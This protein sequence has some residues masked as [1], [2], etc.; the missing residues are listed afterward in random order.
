MLTARDY[1]IV[2]WVGRVGGATAGH[3]MLRFGMGRTA[4]YRRLAHAT[5]DGL[6]DSAQLLYGE[7]TVYV[8]TRRGLRWTGLGH[9]PTGGISPATVAHTM[10]CT[11]V[12]LE[13]EA[14]GAAVVGEREFRAADAASDRPFASVDLPPSHG[15]RAPRHRPDLVVYPGGT[16]LPVAI[17]VELSVKS[18]RRLDLI[19]R[20]WGRARHIA[21]VRYYATP[22][23]ARAVAQA[24]TRTGTE[25][26]VDIRPLPPT[27]LDRPEG[28]SSCR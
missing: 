28:I 11:R 14:E 21:G 8:P 5:H 24:I 27:H 23:V 2:Q 9:L 1:E 6:L 19:C 15:A 17:E 7:P 20:A 18:A 25:G 16:E 4:V 12:W 13:L 22:A 3:T 10:A 26:I